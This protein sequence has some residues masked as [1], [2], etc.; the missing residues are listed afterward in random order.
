MRKED[1]EKFM[2]G[3]E[4]TREILLSVAIIKF[5]FI[6]HIFADN[7]DWQHICNSYLQAL[8]NEFKGAWVKDRTIIYCFSIKNLSNYDSIVSRLEMLDWLEGYL[9]TFEG[10]DL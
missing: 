7:D 1:I 8:S 5:P 2:I 9:L 3:I 10:M 6:C 4:E